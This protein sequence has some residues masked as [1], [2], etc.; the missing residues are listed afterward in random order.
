MAPNMPGWAHPY[1][2]PFVFYA[3][4]GGDP[5]PEPVVEPEPEPDDDPADA[6]TPPSKDEWETFQQ[7]LKTASAEAANRRKW[8]KAAGYDP[9]TGNKIDADPEPATDPEPTA[10]EPQPQ[11]LSPA[12][13]QRQI[14]RAVAEAKI[15]GMRGAKSLATNTLGA[16]SKE[17]WNG[18]RLDLIMP[19]L[20]LDGA[21][22]DDPEDLAERVEHVKSLFPEGFTPLKRT[23]NNPANP[24]N[25][26]APSG[27]NGQPAAKVDAADKKTPAAKP[28][29]WAEALAAQIFPGR[30]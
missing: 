10:P 12:Q 27:Q 15:A 23:R 5:A 22:P 11:G 14:E 16:L 6:W 26:A 18:S 30:Q 19:L 4:G 20:D 17:G 9:K 7:K 1:V 25:L 3:D 8:L 13:V 24:S 2:N 21:D 28:K 29:D